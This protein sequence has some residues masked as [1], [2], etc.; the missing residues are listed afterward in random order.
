MHAQ[1][2]WQGLYSLVKKHQR[3]CEFKPKRQYEEDIPEAVELEIEISE[4]GSNEVIELLTPEETFNNE[5]SPNS[6]QSSKT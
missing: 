5:N 4:D 6:L 3:W 1:C 2:N